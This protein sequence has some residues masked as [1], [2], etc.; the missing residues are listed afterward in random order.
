MDSAAGRVFI[1][2][3]LRIYSNDGPVEDDARVLA[4]RTGLPVKRVAGALESLISAGKI[5]RLEDGKYDILATHDE[6]AHRERLIKNA[7]NAGKESAR[8][9]LI[10]QQIVATTVQPPFNNKTRK[11]NNREEE[12]DSNESRAQERAAFGSVLGR[13]ST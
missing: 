12:K 5:I 7:Q 8:K 2:L 3:L 1:I 10:N 13:V 9:H 4:R 11:E 6:L